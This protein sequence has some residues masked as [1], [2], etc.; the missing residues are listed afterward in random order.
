MRDSGVKHIQSVLQVKA[1]KLEIE[2]L[3]KQVKQI[4]EGGLVTES[5]L[6]EADRSKGLTYVPLNKIPAIKLDLERLMREKAI[7][8][9]IFKVLAK[10][11]ELAKIEASKDQEIIEVIEWAHTPERK[12]K[13]KRALICI[14]A[15]LAAFFLAC[16]YV[17]AKDAWQTSD[18]AVS[19]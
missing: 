18:N 2:A 11:S 9:E 17:L 8:Q 12:S 16:F 19:T 13:P 5:F 1:L 10:E 6:Q 14:V 4:E 7:Q 15:T 3:E